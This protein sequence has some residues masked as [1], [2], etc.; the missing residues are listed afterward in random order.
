[1][2]ELYG[3]GGRQLEVWT[4]ALDLLVLGAG[5]AQL[6]WVLYAMLEKWPSRQLRPESEKDLCGRHSREGARPQRSLRRS[7]DEGMGLIVVGL[8]SPMVVMVSTAAR[9]RPGNLYNHDGAREK[10]SKGLGTI[11]YNLA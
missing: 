3:T 2:R 5:S 4:R 6:R 1:V 7:R 9:K 11:K 8:R 10:P